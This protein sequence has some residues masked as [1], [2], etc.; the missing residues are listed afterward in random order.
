MWPWVVGGVGL[1]LGLLAIL[2][3]IGL[4]AQRFVQN[5]RRAQ[6]TMRQMEQ[7]QR[8]N[9]EEQRRELAEGNGASATGGSERLAR[10]RKVLDEAAG[11]TGGDDRKVLEAGRRIAAGLQP[12]LQAYESAFAGLRDAGLFEPKTLPSREAITVRRERLR[13]LSAANEDLAATYAGMATT[14]RTDLRAANISPTRTEAEAR[15]F[16]TSAQ[17]PDQLQLREQDRQMVRA[18]DELLDLLGREWGQWNVG[19]DGRVIFRK[20]ATLKRFQEVAQRLSAA[21]QAQTELQRRM[22]NRTAVPTPRPR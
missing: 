4:A 22:L 17:L 3:V 10:A 1:L 9:A 5:R 16:E 7:V 14:F 8:Q 15:A 19:P 6:E 13:A 2:A 21:G 12:K 18:G 20:A 11:Q